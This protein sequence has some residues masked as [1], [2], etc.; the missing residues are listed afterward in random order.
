MKLALVSCT[1]VVGVL[2]CEKRTTQATQEAAL[3][4]LVTCAREVDRVA[5]VDRP[6]RM[7][8]LATW[9][10]QEDGCAR[11]VFRGCVD[12][13]PDTSPASPGDGPPERLLI[14][15]CTRAYCD[16]FANAPALCSNDDVTDDAAAEFLAA[17]L[18]LDH[19]LDPREPRIEAVARTYA[20]FLAIEA[21]REDLPAVPPPMALTVQLSAEGYTV[22][23]TGVATMKLA[24]DPRKPLAAADRW[25]YAA[26]GRRARELKTSFPAESSVEIRVGD[27]IPMEA[28]IRT[29]DALIGEGCTPPESE[30]PDCLFWRPFVVPRG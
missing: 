6:A 9:L 24:A 5:N 29:M 28:L 11:G 16:R 19:G 3:D 2:A 10:E 1:I 25:D 14:T 21:A 12:L 23:G 8:E 27:G 26:L 4:R 18:A 22:G 17:K 20:R 13:D 30:D 15:M 7:G